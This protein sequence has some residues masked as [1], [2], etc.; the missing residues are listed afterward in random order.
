MQQKEG[1]MVE[2]AVS[3][4]GRTLA[5]ELH[6]GG[7]HNY[8]DMVARADGALKIDRFACMKRAIER[9]YLV[10]GMVCLRIVLAVTATFPSL[11][12]E[13]RDTRMSSVQGS[14]A[15]SSGFRDAS[16]E[17]GASSIPRLTG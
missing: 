10:W 16:S 15:V 3:S 12:A 5:E 4:V 11:R 9:L 13:L 17:S 14:N 7:P 2:E 6:K 8:D 1:E